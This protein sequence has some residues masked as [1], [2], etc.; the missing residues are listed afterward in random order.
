MRPW[1]K[2]VVC[3][4]IRFSSDPKFLHFQAVKL[5]FDCLKGTD[6]Q[7]LILKSDPENWI[8][9]YVNTNFSGRWNQDKVLDPRLVLSRKGYVVM[10]Y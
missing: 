9:C 8:E 2:F 10:Y 5:I 1:A 3:Q 7:G 6:R 4:C